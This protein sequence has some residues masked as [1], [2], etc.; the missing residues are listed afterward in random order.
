[1]GPQAISSVY[2]SG[3]TASLEDCSLVKQLRLG[4]L[5]GEFKM[6]LHIKRVL[7]LGNNILA[8]T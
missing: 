4:S 6:Y 1:M 2:L 3:Q 8:F 5:R 7:I